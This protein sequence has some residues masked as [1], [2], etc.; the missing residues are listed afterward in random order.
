MKWG[1][2]NLRG[3]P[4]KRKKKKKRSNRLRHELTPHYSLYHYY[5]YVR[6]LWLGVGRSIRENV[7]DVDHNII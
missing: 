5:Q 2:G 4:F 3:R 6:Y 1:I 7:L